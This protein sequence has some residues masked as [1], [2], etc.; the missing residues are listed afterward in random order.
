MSIDKA[1]LHRDNSQVQ[2]KHTN[3]D[4]D[5]DRMCQLAKNSPEL[6][7]QERKKLINN[8]INSAPQNLQKKLQGLQFTI[9]MERR[10]AKTPMNACLRMYQMMWRSVLA[11]NGLLDSLEALS[12]PEKRKKL[13]KSREKKAKVISLQK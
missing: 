4:F 7:E 1:P 3:D 12:K 6:F 13:L 8:L 2:S 9:D 5:F 10:L 11:E